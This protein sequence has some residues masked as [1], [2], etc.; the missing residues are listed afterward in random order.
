MS[1]GRTV[2]NSIKLVKGGGSP[3]K[4]GSLDSKE[5]SFAYT[6]E[7]DTVEWQKRAEAINKTFPLI[8][9]RVTVT[10]PENSPDIA[11]KIT[12]HLKKQNIFTKDEIK[13]GIV[14]QFYGNITIGDT[15]NASQFYS[16]KMPYKLYVKGLENKWVIKGNAQFQQIQAYAGITEAANYTLE[17]KVHRP[18]KEYG[19]FPVDEKNDWKLLKTI[20]DQTIFL[21]SVDGVRLNGPEDIKNR[22]LF[23]LQVNKKI[24]VEY[25]QT[26]EL[27]IKHKEVHGKYDTPADIYELELWRM[28]FEKS[29]K[30]KISIDHILKKGMLGEEQLV[31]AE[32][33]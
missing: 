30:M 19:K 20:N 28:G 1:S 25:I 9:N 8:M 26:G 14:F 12:E 24:P 13:S 10:G 18:Q 3:K 4:I 31:I 33:K 5:K 15:N 21:E 6:D 11:H 32:I 23:Y 22:V 17:G 2:I 16:G 27:E 29:T 7:L